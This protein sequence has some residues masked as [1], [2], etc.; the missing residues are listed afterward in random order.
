[1]AFEI[2][3]GASKKPPRILLIGVEGVALRKL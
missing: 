2:K 3:K 1:M